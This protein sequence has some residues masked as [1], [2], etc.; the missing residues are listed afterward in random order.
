MR[1]ATFTARKEG[2]QRNKKNKREKKTDLLVP[3]KRIKKFV[4]T[5]GTTLRRIV[6]YQEI[7][8]GMIHRFLL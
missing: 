4:K 5:S 3:K 1:L 2:R 8:C 6:D 7:T